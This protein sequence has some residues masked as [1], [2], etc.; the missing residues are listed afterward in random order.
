MPVRPKTYSLPTGASVPGNRVGRQYRSTIQI[1]HR[2]Q[3][4]VGEAGTRSLWSE[5][6]PKVAAR[7]NREAVLFNRT[8]Y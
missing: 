3:V 4:S 5:A 8:V 1:A 7:G 2:H 6:I